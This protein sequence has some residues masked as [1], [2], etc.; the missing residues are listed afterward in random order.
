M[1][2]P[3][4]YFESYSNLAYNAAGIAALVLHGDVLFCM[5]M[6]AL[7]IG[8]FVYHFDKSGDRENN[9]IWKFDWW[10]MAFVNTVIAGIHFN[11]P[12]TWMLLVIFHIVYGYFIMGKLHVFLEA[13]ASALIAL[14]AIYLNRSPTTFFI[15]L[16]VFLLAF[17]IRSRDEDPKQLKFHDSAWH[18]AWHIL[19]AVCFYLAVYLNL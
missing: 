8:S 7:G 5:A 9:P 14:V 19:T 10:A 18:S 15:I 17:F 16:G 12:T 13:G 3:K 6:Q 4:E 2:K 11:S 1:S